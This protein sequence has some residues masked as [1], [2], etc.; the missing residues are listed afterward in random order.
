MVKGEG[1]CLSSAMLLKVPWWTVSAT[2]VTNSG[3]ILHWQP[4]PP[5]AA[6]VVLRYID[7]GNLM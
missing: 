5:M 7:L 1:T 2:D 3:L 4:K 6:D